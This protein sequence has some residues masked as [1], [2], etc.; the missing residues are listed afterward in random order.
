MKDVCKKCRHK[1][2]CKFPCRPVEL[3]LAEDNLSVFEKT[4]TRENGETVS[5]VYA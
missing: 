4:V 5:I 3:Y 1:K 2:T